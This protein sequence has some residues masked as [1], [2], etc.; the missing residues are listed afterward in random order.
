M[1]CS[2]ANSWTGGGAVCCVHSVTFPG[3]FPASLNDPIPPKESVDND[4]DFH[5]DGAGEEDEGDLFYEEL[6]ALVLQPTVG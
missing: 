4:T 5:G 2:V 1:F 6:D 3:H